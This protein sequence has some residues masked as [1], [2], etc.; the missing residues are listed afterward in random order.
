MDYVFSCIQCSSHYCY[1]FIESDNN[2]ISS[3]LPTSGCIHS[4]VHFNIHWFSLKF[5]YHLLVCSF[6]HSVVYLFIC[7]Y[8]HDHSFIQSVTEPF[9]CSFICSFI[10]SYSFT[11]YCILSAVFPQ[12]GTLMPLHVHNWKT[13][14]WK[15]ARKDAWSKRRWNLPALQV[16]AK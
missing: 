15:S 16:Y 10:Y 6:N 3:Y 4:F 13:L 2:M 5:S 8:T 14:H 12:L 9:I 1:Q 11:Y 7:S